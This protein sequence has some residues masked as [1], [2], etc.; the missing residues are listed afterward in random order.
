MSKPSF[1]WEKTVKPEGTMA[2]NACNTTVDEYGRELLEHGTLAFPIAC[3]HDDFRISD[4]P[5]HWHEEWEA[6]LIT[7]GSCLVAAGNQKERLQAGMGFFIHSGVLHGC[8]DTE[9]SG[10]TFHSM[11]F[12]PRLVGGNSDSIFHRQ[13]VQPLLDHS[14][15]E[16]IVLNPDVPWQNRALEAIE[17]AWQECAAETDGFQFRVRNFLSELTWLLFRNLSPAAASPRAKDLRDARRIKRM[18]SCIHS[19]FGSELTTAGIAASASVSES[20]CLRCFRT[21]IG[22]TPI[23]YLKQYRIRQAARMLTESQRKISDIAVSCGFQDMSYFTKVFREQLGC[24]P[25]Q[26][27]KNASP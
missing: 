15:P 8:W 13:F 27:R 4:V 26:Y 23:Q 5:W 20:E 14:G 2:L 16:L 1:Y 18:L 22:I 24:S 19:Q 10:C 9:N 6:V 11:V 17:A 25:S 7:R 12:H 3:Y 21:T